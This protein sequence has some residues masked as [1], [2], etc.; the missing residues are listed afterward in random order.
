[1]KT[2]ALEERASTTTPW[3]PYDASQMQISL[4]IWK[5]D[6]SLAFADLQKN[7]VAL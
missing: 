6:M 4:S 1:M 2:L 3:K 7:K 5:P